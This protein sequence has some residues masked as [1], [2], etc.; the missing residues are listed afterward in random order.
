V[1]VAYLYFNYQRQDEQKV[2]TL[3]PCLLKQLAQKWTSFQGRPDCINVLYNA[4]KHK[5]TRPLFEEIAKA[6]HSMASLYSRVFI[7]IDALDEFKASERTE[8]L[9]RLFELQVQRRANILMTSRFISGLQEKF[10]DNIH[11][12]L[13]VRASSEDVRRYLESHMNRLQPVEDSPLLQEEV[14]TRII[15]LTDGM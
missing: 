7:I 14:K 11:T 6:V 4:H 3:F 12:T 13:E 9:T 10:S 5:G 8:F 15:Q 1:G 2:E